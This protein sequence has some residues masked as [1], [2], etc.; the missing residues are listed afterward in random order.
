MRFHYIGFLAALISI[1]AVAQD[2]SG[3]LGKIRDT[4]TINVGFQEASVPFSYLDD[5]Q[6]PVGY[7]IDICLKIAEAAGEAA[8]VQNLTIRYVPVTPANRTPLLLNG[9]ID[10]H[11]ASATNT[12][13]R[14]QQVDFVN[15]HFLTANRFLT[16]VSSGISTVEDLRGK[17]VVSTAGSIGLN[18]LNQLNASKG[19]GIRVLSA[20]DQLEGFLM[21]ETD[22]AAAFVQDDVQLAVA[23]ARSR[24]PAD[25]VLGEE[26]LSKPDPIGI[27]IRKNDPQFL[28]LTDRVTTDLYA[29]PEIIEIYKKWFESPVPPNGINFAIPISE[30]LRNAF[31]HPSN[32]YNPDDYLP[33]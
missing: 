27:M 24:N 12:A 1:P 25:F 5:N 32:S 11:C 10:L 28:D 26:A 29:S 15:T 13:E 23:A 14:Q 6:Q 2:L 8:G 7:T 16:K 22:R 31:A 20:R 30:E 33:R 19:F 18:L 21:L 17:P 4:S 3:T 9:T